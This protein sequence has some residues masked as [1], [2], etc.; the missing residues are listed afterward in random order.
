MGLSNF[1]PSWRFLSVFFEF[2]KIKSS[3]KTEVSQITKYLNI[4]P[5]L[6]AHKNIQKIKASMTC[7]AKL[8]YL[9]K[10]ASYAATKIYCASDDITRFDGTITSFF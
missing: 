6:T 7:F 3:P 8:S 5:I 9:H 1:G 4:R 2:P 10:Q